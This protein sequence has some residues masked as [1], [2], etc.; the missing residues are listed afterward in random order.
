MYE[1][2]MV[3]LRETH[4]TPGTQEEGKKAFFVTREDDQRVSK[5]SPAFLADYY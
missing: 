3:S 5:R 2:S 4:F 1:W